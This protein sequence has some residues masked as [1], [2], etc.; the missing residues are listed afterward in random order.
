[1]WF[2]KARAR[3]FGALRN[4]EL[5]LNSGLNVIHG[6]NEAGKST[7]HAAMTAALCG[8]RRGRGRDKAREELE[9]HCPWESGDDS[10]WEI[11]VEIELDDGRGIELARNF[12]SNA[13]DLRDPILGTEIPPAFAGLD[14]INN[15]SPD[16]ARLVGLDRE[17]FS[18]VASVRQARVVADLEEADALQTH[19]A[20]A[21]A[22]SENGTAADAIN[23]IRGFK[24]ENVGVARKKAEK[25]L[26]KAIEA[27]D[28]AT[29]HLSE[30]RVAHADYLREF[31]SFDEK[32]REQG[33]LQRDLSVAKAAL[34]WRR[35][36]DR[37]HGLS[38]KVRTL[39]ALAERA[40]EGAC[41]DELVDGPNVE[42]PSA[43]DSPPLPA[44]AGPESRLVVRRW[45][46]AAPAAAGLLAGVLVG[47]VASP[48]FGA[49]AGI[50]VMAGTAVWWSR[51]RS[52]GAEGSV[53]D[54]QHDVGVLEQR[55][56]QPDEAESSRDH[57]TAVTKAASAEGELRN[58]L[59]GRTLADW[60]SDAEEARRDEVRKRCD[61]ESIGGSVDA[62]G[63]LEDAEG[64]LGGLDCRRQ[65]TELQLSRLEGRLSRVC[66]D[67][68]DVAAAEASFAEAEAELTR[69]R[70]LEATLDKTM[71][72]LEQAAD[73]AHRLLAPRVASRVSDLVERVTDGRYREVLVDPRSLNV[74]LIAASG[75]RH[76]ARLASRGTIEQVYLALRLVL[77]QVLSDGA[78]RC[79]VLLDDPTVH[80]DSQRKRALLECLLDISREYQV[81]LFSQEQEVLDWARSRSDAGVHLIELGSVQPA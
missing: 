77:A 59:E 1:M 74:T 63:V 47:F 42:I 44:A 10:P 4:D 5:P 61:L 81:I 12:R 54:G 45:L 68:V 35:A 37:A 49:I 16:G 21:A 31:E 29:G 7:W 22:G 14:L 6:P 55:D 2:R 75:E 33:Q 78:Q 8:Q 57:L 23:R 48:R 24:K 79:P 80:A 51:H 73:S 71:A 32:R 43:V 46:G 41:L 39:E 30:V 69:V 56:R 36:F 3:A 13:T 19:L 72:L 18:M 65:Q 20:R 15:G 76:A 66:Q 53:S 9:R 60:R 28:Q 25:P 62:V 34:S 38:H 11:A 26:Q 58:A 67:S 50:L 52:S 70:S 27:H 64:H 40:D 17:T